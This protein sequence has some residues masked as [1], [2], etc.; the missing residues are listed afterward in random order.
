[1]FLFSSWL[2]CFLAKTPSLHLSENLADLG[3][4]GPLLAQAFSIGVNS[5]YS[6]ALLL[7]MARVTNAHDNAVFL[8]FLK[9]HKRISA[10]KKG[11]LCGSPNVN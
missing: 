11:V 1:M 5:D 7:L 3:N 9:P 10:F 6:V 4:Y 8:I 2:H